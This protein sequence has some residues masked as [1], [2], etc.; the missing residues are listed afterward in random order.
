MKLIINNDEYSEFPIKKIMIDCQCDDIKNLFIKELKDD[1]NLEIENYVIAYIYLEKN[2]TED[3]Y[4][5]LV[6][7]FSLNKKRKSKIKLDNNKELI[8]YFDKVLKI[9]RSE[10]PGESKIALSIYKLKEEI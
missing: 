1:I 5:A 4:Y 7:Y 3:Q 9:F 2:Y 10:N 6:N 8:M